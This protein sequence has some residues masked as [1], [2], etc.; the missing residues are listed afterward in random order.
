MNLGTICLPL[1]VDSDLEH[2][3][4]ITCVW[5]YSKIYLLFLGCILLPHEDCIY[6]LEHYKVSQISPGLQYIFCRI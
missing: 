4:G 3:H 2:T 1:F 6:I 5:E